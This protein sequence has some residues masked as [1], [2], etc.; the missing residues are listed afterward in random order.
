MGQG[1]LPLVYRMTRVYLGTPRGS[2]RGVHRPAAA[3][4]P[5]VP[6][7]SRRE[8]VITAAITDA[9]FDTRGAIYPRPGRAARQG[10]QPIG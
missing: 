9:G 10:L 4:S 8:S 1:G 5:S 7:T 6:A 2:R 3:A